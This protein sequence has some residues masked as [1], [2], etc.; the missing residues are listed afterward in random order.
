MDKQERLKETDHVETIRNVSY[1]S[2]PKGSRGIVRYTSS[3]ENVEVRFYEASGYESLP[4]DQTFEREDLKKVKSPKHNFKKGDRVEVVMKGV[5]SITDKG[6]LGRVLGSDGNLVKVDFDYIT[7]ELEDYI[8]EYS[9]QPFC[10]KL[11]KKRKPR[12]KK[13]SEK[14]VIVSDNERDIEIAKLFDSIEEAKTWIKQEEVDPVICKLVPIM[15]VVV[16]TQTI[17]KEIKYGGGKH[18]KTKKSR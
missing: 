10:L 12:P 1:S 5:H 4:I 3:G 7:G 9:V 16:E 13:L 8:G 11:S 15:R 18:G 2:V 14:Y 17:V 6:S